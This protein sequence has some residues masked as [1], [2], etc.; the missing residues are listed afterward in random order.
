MKLKLTLVAVALVT[1]ALLGMSYK[2]D[3]KFD[4]FIGELTAVTD[5]MAAEGSRDLSSEGVE[6]AKKILDAQKPDLKKRLDELKTVPVSQVDA[7]T[8]ERFQECIRANRTKLKDVFL[9]NQ[10]VKE[11]DLKD[12]EFLGNVARLVDDYVSLFE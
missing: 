5:R 1:I 10:A 9:D 3:D 7:K 4:K 8:L 11:A 2:R 12:P 6:R